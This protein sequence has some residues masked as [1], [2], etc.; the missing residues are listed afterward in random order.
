VNYERNKK[1]ARFFE[2]QC[3]IG[4]LINISAMSKD[5]KPPIT[6]VLLRQITTFIIINNLH[7]FRSNNLV[8]NKNSIYVQI[9][10]NKK[11]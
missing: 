4:T 7:N 2:T 6:A 11:S 3:I 5:I 8:S 10:I 1:G 9:K